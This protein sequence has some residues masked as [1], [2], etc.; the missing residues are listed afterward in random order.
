VS[1]K[2]VTNHNVSSVLHCIYYQ[3]TDAFKEQHLFQYVLQWFSNW[4]SRFTGILGNF[5]GSSYD[6]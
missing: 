3:L 5:I 2:C 4:G 6:V 1:L